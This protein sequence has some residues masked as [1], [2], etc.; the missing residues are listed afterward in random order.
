[1]LDI[2]RPYLMISV[3]YF[4]SLISSAGRGKSLLRKGMEGR[5]QGSIFSIFILSA[6]T[7]R[8]PDLFLMSIYTEN[9]CLQ[10]NEVS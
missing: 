4:V 8:S 1:M 10:L 6:V 5:H 3:Y 2:L 7:Q 9:I